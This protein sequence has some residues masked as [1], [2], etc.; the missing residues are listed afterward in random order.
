MFGT[1]IAVAPRDVHTVSWHEQR[2]PGRSRRGVAV[3]VL[4]GGAPSQGAG[5][6][7]LFG[8]SSSCPG[9]ADRAAA[10]GR[11]RHGVEPA[12]RGRTEGC[13]GVLG[14]IGHLLTLYTP[15]WTLIMGQTDGPAWA[16]I[17]APLPEPRRETDCRWTG[18][19]I[20][21]TSLPVLFRT[22]RPQPG[23]RLHRP[24]RIS[25][26]RAPPLELLTQK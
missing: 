22:L 7:R 11:V 16:V 23:C 20:S 19:G 21:S 24:L 17:P 5:G 15:P 10:Q 2:Q 1:T 18:S 6:P 13:R 26:L 9:Q 14:V 4:V 8:L 25:G 3:A 12:F